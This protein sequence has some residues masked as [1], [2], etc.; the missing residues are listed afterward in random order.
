MNC[1]NNLNKLQ[2]FF[3]C[4]IVNQVITTFLDLEIIT[5]RFIT[6]I[7]EIL[8]YLNIDDLK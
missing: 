6:V 7:F 3:L 1:Q 4:F 8:F 5:H 2:V